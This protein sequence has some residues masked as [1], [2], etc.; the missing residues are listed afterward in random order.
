LFKK[1]FVKNNKPNDTYRCA[2]S[3][4][5]WLDLIIPSRVGVKEHVL[6]FRTN[7]ERAESK[8]EQ[9]AVYLLSGVFVTMISNMFIFA[10]IARPFS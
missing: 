4:G 6:T 1:N 2:V 8:F 3:E 7:R 5:R 10:F 9:P